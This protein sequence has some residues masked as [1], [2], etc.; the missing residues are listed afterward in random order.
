MKS[1]NNENGE[2]WRKRR[3]GV[4]NGEIIAIAYHQWRNGEMK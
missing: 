1:E 2:S 4:N 3:N